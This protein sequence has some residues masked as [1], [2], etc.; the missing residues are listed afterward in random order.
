[1]VGMFWQ[2]WDA[3][4][5]GGVAD[6]RLVKEITW[7]FLVIGGMWA[8]YASVGRAEGTIVKGSMPLFVTHV[9]VFTGP[10]R[11]RVVCSQ[12]L[13]FCVLTLCVR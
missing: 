5:V 3:C 10:L 7:S 1:M 13:L 2:N 8:W 11:V 9:R 6:C 12:D 4:T